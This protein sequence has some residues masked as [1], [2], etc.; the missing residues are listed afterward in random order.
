MKHQFE[1]SCKE[2]GARSF[3]DPDNQNAVKIIFRKGTPSTMDRII[4]YCSKC[5]NSQEA[6][7][8]YPL[9]L[10]MKDILNPSES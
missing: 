9:D 5:G 1:I 2:C 10:D 4:V 7:I 3:Y 6:G 8:Y